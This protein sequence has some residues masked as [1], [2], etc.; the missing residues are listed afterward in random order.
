[1]GG[2]FWIEDFGGSVLWDFFYLFDLAFVRVCSFEGVGFVL[3]GLIME[4]T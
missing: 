4:G 3:A 2:W 1:V